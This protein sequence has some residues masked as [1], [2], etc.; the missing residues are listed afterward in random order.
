MPFNIFDA[1]VPFVLLQ[2]SDD[3]FALCVRH[4]PPKLSL[5]GTLLPCKITGPFC[6][7]AGA[8][9]L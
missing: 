6:Q 9:L 2:L 7:M 1:N 8:S 3:V 5:F 4:F